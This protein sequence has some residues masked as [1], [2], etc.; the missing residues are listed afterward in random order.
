LSTGIVRIRLSG[1]REDLTKLAAA[2]TA[3]PGLTVTAMSLREN[4]R[5]P[6]MRGYLTAVIAQSAEKENGNAKPDA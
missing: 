1:E 5:D 2:I 4:Y 3:L 6:G